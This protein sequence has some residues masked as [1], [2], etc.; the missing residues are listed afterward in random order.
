MSAERRASARSVAVARRRVAVVP[1][2][3]C[4]IMVVVLLLSH[5]LNSKRRNPAGGSGQN[6][7]VVDSML[8]GAPQN[9]TE[10]T[11]SDCVLWWKWAIRKRGAYLSLFRIHPSLCIA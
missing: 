1:G 2:Y 3:L 10:T 8:S 6:R 7:K 4:Q 5:F 9:A 11:S